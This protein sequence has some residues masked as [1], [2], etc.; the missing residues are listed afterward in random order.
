[1]IDWQPAE[2]SS[3]FA[4]TAQDRSQVDVYRGLLEETLEWF[5]GQYQG[6]RAR[7]D[8]VDR[9]REELERE[10]VQRQYAEAKLP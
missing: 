6:K 9:I 3:K 4:M 10:K 5:Q 7:R 1:M 8:L 2:T